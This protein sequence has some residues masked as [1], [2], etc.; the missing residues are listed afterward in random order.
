MQTCNTCVLTVIKESRVLSGKSLK[1]L[2]KEIEQG[3]T[4]AIHLDISDSCITGLGFDALANG[5]SLSEITYRILLLWKRRTSRMKEAQVHMLLQAL[6]DMGRNDA[7]SIVAEQHRHNRELTPDCFEMPRYPG[8][9]D[10][11]PF[12]NSQM[13]GSPPPPQYARTVKT[14]SFSL[15]TL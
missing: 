15:P 6:Q 13:L 3:L 12:L 2:A 11:I 10:G 8:G 9:D 5:L 14:T 1:C 7:A 4:L